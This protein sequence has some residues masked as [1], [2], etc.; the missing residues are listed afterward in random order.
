MKK[1]CR[2]HL[3]GSTEIIGDRCNFHLSAV[4]LLDWADGVNGVRRDM[5]IER[6]RERKR[7]RRRIGIWDLGG[8]NCELRR[9]SVL[10]RIFGT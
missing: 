9:K 8:A 1:Q 7:D 3:L 6:V 10:R 5:D 4:F 2:F